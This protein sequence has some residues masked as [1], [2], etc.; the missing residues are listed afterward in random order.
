[1]ARKIF[2]VMDYLVGKTMRTEMTKDLSPGDIVRVLEDLAAHGGNVQLRK[3]WEG[4][5]VRIVW[6]GDAIISFERRHDVKDVQKVRKHNFS[7]LRVLDT[8]AKSKWERKVLMEDLYSAIKNKSLK[9]AFDVYQ[10]MAKHKDLYLKDGTTDFVKKIWTDLADAEAERVKE[11][12]REPLRRVKAKLKEP[13][14]GRL[15]CLASSPEIG[16][17]GVPV[18]SIAAWAIREIG[19]NNVAGDAKDQFHKLLMEP[20]A[21]TQEIKGWRIA[22]KGKLEFFMESVGDS[23]GPVTLYSLTGGPETQWERAYLQG[24]FTKVHNRR[25]IDVRCFDRLE[26]FLD[27]LA[28]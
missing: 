4:I 8:E 27:H 9:K 21:M 18:L 14:Q 22:W 28:L 3:E 10:E 5:V 2:V 19:F 24:E 6:L 17:D 12:Y 13:G 15:M 16:L 7:K 25:V 23:A 26:T 11:K 20:K 1:L